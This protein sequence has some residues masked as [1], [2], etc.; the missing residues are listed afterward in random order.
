MRSSIRVVA[1]SVDHGNGG[2]ESCRLHSLVC[3][4][5]AEAHLEAIA[6]EGL[7]RI[8]NDL[9][10]RDEVHHGAA[11]DKDPC[12]AH[13]QRISFMSGGDARSS[14]PIGEKGMMPLITDECTV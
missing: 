5:A 12:C 2:A 4:F 9:G 10:V 7:T 8:G 3:T 1:D 14:P 6:N 11:D 13:V